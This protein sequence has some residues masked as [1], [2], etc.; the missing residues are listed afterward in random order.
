[1]TLVD[2]SA[3]IRSEPPDYPEPLRTEIQFD[4]HAQGAT[5]IGTLFGVG[6]ELYL[7]PRS[8]R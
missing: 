2:L 5:T 8:G 1:M 7:T 4:D 3:P 6:T